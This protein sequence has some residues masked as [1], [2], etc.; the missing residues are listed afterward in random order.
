[1]TS[2]S[3][4]WVSLPERMRTSAF[5]GCFVD[6]ELRLLVLIHHCRRYEQ[7]YNENVKPD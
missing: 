5:S 4:G 6:G 1:M 2:V 3:H 7:A